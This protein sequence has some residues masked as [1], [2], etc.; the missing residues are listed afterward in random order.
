LLTT[1]IIYW[2][3][4]DNQ[5]SPKYYYLGAGGAS[6][7]G[8]FKDYITQGLAEL[9]MMSCKKSQLS[10]ELGISNSDARSKILKSIKS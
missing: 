7:L 9:I 2:A 5:V 3:G 6:Q 1:L 10:A 4:L 8:N